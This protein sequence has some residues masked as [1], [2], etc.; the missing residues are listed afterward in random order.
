MTTPNPPIEIT[1][2]IP[3]QWSGPREVVERLPG[4]YSIEGQHLSMP[5]GS[6]V[7]IYPRP[8]DDQFAGIFANAC[9]QPPEDDEQEIINQYT[10]NICLCGPGGSM[11]QALTMM[12]A[13]SAIV[14]AGGA[15]VFIDN[16]AMAHGGQLWQEMAEDGGSD[17]LTFA[18]VSVINNGQEIWTMGMHILGYPDLVMRCQDHETD[19]ETIIETVRYVG[20]GEKPIGDGHLLGDEHG[21]RF[22]ATAA[23][24]Q[25]MPADSPMYNPFRRLRLTSL[26]DIAEGN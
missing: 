14:S 13:G 1:F 3:G 2:R 5:D 9:R 8:A 20:R 23:D 7:E 16:C 25:Q 22:Q 12:Q 19:A 11:E 24:D 21:A 10:V 15:G 4:G 17:A 18:Y 6:K 26:K